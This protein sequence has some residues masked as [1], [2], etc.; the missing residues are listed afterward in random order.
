M[1][2][3]QTQTVHSDDAGIPS[4]LCQPALFWVLTLIA[5]SFCQFYINLKNVILYKFYLKCC[6][7]HDQQSPDC[8]SPDSDCHYY[9]LAA[10]YRV[11]AS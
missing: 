5:L 7:E 2:S 4:C 1:K 3:F 11:L 8:L 9:I 6:S 10:E